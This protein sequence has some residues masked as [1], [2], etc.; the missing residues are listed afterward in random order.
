M[1]PCINLQCGKLSFELLL[2]VLNLPPVVH[3]QPMN[4]LNYALIAFNI[5]FPK[6]SE[7]FCIITNEWHDGGRSGPQLI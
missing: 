7:G 1:C 4:P 5:F 2:M 3:F 6:I